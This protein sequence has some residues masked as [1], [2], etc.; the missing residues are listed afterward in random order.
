MSDIKTPG[1]QSSEVFATL[2]SSLE[3]LPA[4]K[5]AQ[6]LKQVKGIF[7]FVIENND[8]KKETFTIDLKKDG[9]VVKGQGAT[10]ADAIITIKDG[11]FVDLAS[12][13]LNGQKAFTSGKLKIKGQMMLATKLDTV[14]KQL[15][16]NKS[17]L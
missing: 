15:A 17:K 5:K 11:D 10:K 7:E 13:K 8:K 3:S 6:L 14:F 16:G 2:K 9:T 12:G 4:D 1:F